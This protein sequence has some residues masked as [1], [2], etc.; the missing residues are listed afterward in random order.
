[1]DIWDIGFTLARFFKLVP[2]EGIKNNSDEEAIEEDA[3]SVKKIVSKGLYGGRGMN[4]DVYVFFY[5][6]LQLEFFGKIDRMFCAVGSLHGCMRGGWVGRDGTDVI[7]TDV[8]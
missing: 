6:G 8:V 7:I 5:K 2:D 1:M 4:R 3:K